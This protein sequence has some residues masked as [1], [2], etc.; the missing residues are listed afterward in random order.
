MSDIQPNIAP[1]GDGASQRHEQHPEV[2][3]HKAV[4]DMEVSEYREQDRY[5]PVRAI[6]CHWLLNIGTNQPHALT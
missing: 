3:E 6:V 2:H 1:S 4:T 5:L